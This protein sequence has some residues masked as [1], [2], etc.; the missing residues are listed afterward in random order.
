MIRR[1]FDAEYI[2]M[3]ANH[4]S[5]RGGAKIDM[6]GHDA[7]FSELVANLDNLLL[8][9]D[10][11]CFLL[12]DKGYGVYEVHT[13]ALK[14]GRGKRLR[15]MVLEMLEYLFGFA[16]ADKLETMVFADNQAAAKL[17][18]EFMPMIREEG[19]IKYYALNKSDYLRRAA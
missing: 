12:I 5:V 18:E 6:L 2:N 15:S 17:A 11:G 4:P 7:D 9:Y 8:V 3:V 13:M 16:H 14:H 19:G 1:E 10:G